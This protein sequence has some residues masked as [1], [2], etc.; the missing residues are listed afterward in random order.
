MAKTLRIIT[1]VLAVFL[2]AGGCATT[3]KQE[4]VPPV[5]GAEGVPR[6]AWVET[7]PKSDGYHYETGYAKLSTKANSI[8]RA[9][10]DGKEKIAQW[11]STAVRTVVVNYISDA[12][13]DG[14]LQSLDAF[15]SISRQ[16][17]EASLYGVTQEGLWVDPD[18]GVWILLSIPI[19][20]TVKAFEAAQNDFIDDDPAAFAE[21]RKNEALAA[22]ERTLAGL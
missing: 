20:N 10:A 16:V 15:E 2:L 21:Y 17:S 5:V 8:K 9:S 3:A 1:V 6:P 19:E 7:G 4:R 13:S 14:N 11:I 18:G 22:L 12:G